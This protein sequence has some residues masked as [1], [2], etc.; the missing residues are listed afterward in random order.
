LKLDLPPPILVVTL[1]LPSPELS[2]NARISRWKKS[3]LIQEARL[4]ARQVFKE[5]TRAPV[6]GSRVEWAHGKGWRAGI[7]VA[8]YGASSRNDESVAVEFPSGCCATI[9]THRLRVVASPWPL[10]GATCI[11]VLYRK[12]GSALVIDEDNALFLCKA[13]I[14]GAQDAGLVANDRALRHLPAELRVD[15]KRPRL[16][17]HVWPGRLEYTGK[18][19][20]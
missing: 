3:K 20:P 9:A 12:T 8:R 5:A 6:V 11:P 10:A 17:I 1:P 16:E 14:D 19:A 4:V 7:V 15:K 18:G 2:A 13:S